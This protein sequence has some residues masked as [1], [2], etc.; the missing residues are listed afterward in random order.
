MAPLVI[1]YCRAA[2][3]PC[4]SIATGRLPPIRMRSPQWPES[5]PDFN[6]VTSGTCFSSSVTEEYDHAR[7]SER[8]PDA[9]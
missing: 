1:D 5:R 4:G 7:S 8:Y 9:S 2:H 6:A 3:V